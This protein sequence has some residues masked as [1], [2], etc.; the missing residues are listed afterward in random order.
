MDEFI[1]AR[2][3]KVMRGAP[4]HRKFRRLARTLAISRFDALGVTVALW[5]WVDT[6][7][8]Y[9]DLPKHLTAIDIADSLGIDHID[10]DDL[11]KGWIDAS[12]IDVDGD[13]LTIHGWMDEHRTGASA[14]QRMWVAQK[15]AH[16]RWH[17]KAKDRKPDA[18]QFCAKER[19]GALPK[20]AQA[21]P[22]DAPL[23]S[24]LSPKGVLPTAPE[25]TYSA[26][27]PERPFGANEEGAV[28]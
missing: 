5:E 2:F 15:A 14:E 20:D 25:E 10:P 16:I 9:G 3:I 8:P 18:C 17:E 19:T 1:E 4:I 6:N 28:A 22:T 12:L 13:T 21:L 11:L 26:D 7:W 23:S 24:D 27:D